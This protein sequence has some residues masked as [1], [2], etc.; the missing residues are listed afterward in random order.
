MTFSDNK[1]SVFKFS[2]NWLAINLFS[3]RIFSVDTCAN[4]FVYLLQGVP[5]NMTV[6]EK[7]RMSSS[8][9]C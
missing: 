3:Y 9:I 7:F 6:G 4:I 2:L 1:N 8:I 5:Q